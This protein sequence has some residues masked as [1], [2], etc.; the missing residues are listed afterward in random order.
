MIT[1][2]PIA[3]IIHLDRITERLAAAGVSRSVE[4]VGDYD[5]A[6]PSP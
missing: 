3:Q 4:T 1:G 2:P 5:N 6:W